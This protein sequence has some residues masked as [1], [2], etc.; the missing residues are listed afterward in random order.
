MIEGAHREPC[1]CG[2]WIWPMYVHHDD[3]VMYQCKCGNKWMQERTYFNHS[4]EKR[5]CNGHCRTGQASAP[6]KK[7]QEGFMTQWRKVHGA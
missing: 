6:P 4:C 1:R 2:K 7:K 3:T 5:K